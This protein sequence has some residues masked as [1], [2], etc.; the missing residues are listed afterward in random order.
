MTT[1]RGPSTVGGFGFW[2]GVWMIHLR[3]PQWINWNVHSSHD[4]Y[5]MQKRGRQGQR[6]KQI[7]PRLQ[8]HP[9]KQQHISPPGSSPVHL[10]IK[11]GTCAPIL[12]FSS[13][14]F[15]DI[16]RQFDCQKSYSTSFL[17]PLQNSLLKGLE[18]VEKY[19]SFK[20]WKSGRK[21]LEYIMHVSTYLLGEELK[22][23]SDGSSQGRPHSFIHWQYKRPFAESGRKY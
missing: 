7:C 23:M 16:C 3:I 12:H 9:A 19:V 10:L 5:N 18:T 2:D 22:T 13:R 6:Q 20:K 4:L 11:G 8:I 14:T 15:M 21:I 17:Y 1:N